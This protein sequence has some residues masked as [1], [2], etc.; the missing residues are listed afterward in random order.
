MK[1]HYFQH[2]PFEGLG[3]MAAC[4]LNSGHQLSATRLYLDDPIPSP[5]DIDW[6]IVMGGPMG[7][8]DEVKYPW[9]QKEKTFIREVIDAGKKVFGICLGAQLIASVLGA[10]VIKNQHREIGWFPLDVSPE[11]D[12]TVL[13]DLFQPGIEVFHW[14]GDTFDIPPS[15]RLIASSKACK[16]Q[17]FIV[18]DRIVG[19]QFHLETTPDSAGAL[20]QHCGDELDGSTYVQNA[21]E[22]LSNPKRFLRINELM[23]VI[24]KRLEK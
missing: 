16:N 15:G 6:L 24:L 5:N 2:V 19:F 9:M 22:M 11:A 8:N 12:G 23:E 20:I 21:S 14:H 13:A 10:A 3:S 17:G 7:A 18:E 4:F 1:I